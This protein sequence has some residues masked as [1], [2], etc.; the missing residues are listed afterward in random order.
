MMKMATTRKIRVG[1][2]KLA[3]TV[4][5]APAIANFIIFTSLRVMKMMKLAATYK[6]GASAAKLANTTTRAPTPLV[7]IGVKTAK[8]ADT[9]VA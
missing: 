7:K 9:A 2:T 6:I 8:M 5:R 1:A 4:T 3:D